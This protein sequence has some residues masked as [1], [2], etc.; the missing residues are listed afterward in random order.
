MP[1]RYAVVCATCLY[2]SAHSSR[3]EANIDV[4]AHLR[5]NPTHAVTVV[6][7]GQGATRSK[8]S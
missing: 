5:D 7:E 8:A 1:S 2:R 4:A 3:W 6:E